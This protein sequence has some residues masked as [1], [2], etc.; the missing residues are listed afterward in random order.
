[1]NEC[2]WKGSRLESFL[3]PSPKTEWGNVWDRCKM[4]SF[5]DHK[6]QVWKQRKNNISYDSGWIKKSFRYVSPESSTRPLKTF[7]L[8]MIHKQ[9]CFRVHGILNCFMFIFQRH[10]KKKESQ[11]ATEP[12]FWNILN[13]IIIAHDS[14]W[15]SSQDSFLFRVQYRYAFILYSDTAETHTYV[16]GNL[17]EREVKF[18]I[19]DSGNAW[20][21]GAVSTLKNI[22][23][24][25]SN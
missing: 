4:H 11:L 7:L 6:M 18:D 10:A 23:K 5:H 9:N 15:F 17:K 16:A 1:M 20:D 25:H 12:T 22:I 14:C 21:L 3:Y 19:E 2:A 13:E 24:R 8:R